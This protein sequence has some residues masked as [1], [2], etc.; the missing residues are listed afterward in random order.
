MT[1]YLSAAGLAVY[2]IALSTAFPSVQDAW[3][4]LG[5]LVPTAVAAEAGAPT[6]PATAATADA[7]ADGAGPDSVASTAPEW[8]PDRDGM[9]M[10][11][12]GAA[13]PF[14]VLNPV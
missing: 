13:E 10:D 14:A 11:G 9:L 1:R 6:A 7:A 2:A 4:S 5:G 12:A 3:K 8:H